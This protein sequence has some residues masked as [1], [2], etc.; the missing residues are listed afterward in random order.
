MFSNSG[1]SLGIRAY[2]D[3]Q[4]G[5]EITIS[6]KS[7][8]PTHLHHPN[9]PSDL[10]LGKP[11][12]AR[13]EGLKRW[14]FNCTC[15]LCTAPPAIRAAHDT[16]RNRIAELEPQLNTLYREGKH[17]AA[18][19]AGEEIV[20][21]ML[22]EGLTSLLPEVYVM[23]TRLYLVTEQRERAEEAA[24]L[25]LEILE[26]LGFLGMEGREGWGL[27]RLLGVFVDRGVY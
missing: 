23:L 14:G 19:A 24:D 22:E 17:N 21:L 13:Q 9:I 10:L 20:E 26:D 11:H 1:F 12:A 18:I 5:E 6:C 3:I 25:A 7:P 4:P 15:A 16:R 27:E 8:F 2:R